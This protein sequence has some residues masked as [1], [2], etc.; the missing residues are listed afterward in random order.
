MGYHLA[1]KGDSLKGLYA[2]CDNT[3]CP[4]RSHFSLAFD[5]LCGG[6]PILQLRMKGVSLKKR[7]EVAQR[8]MRLKRQFFF[9]FIINDDPELV[10]DVGA[11]GAHVG[12]GDLSVD[13][14]RRFLGPSKLI[15]YSAHSLEEAREAEAAGADY[16][17][18]GAIFPSPLKGPGHPVQG[19]KR[20]R[21]V[22]S[23]LSIPVV[24]I[25]GI[26]H[27]NVQSVLETGVASVAMISALAGASN[28][29][30]ATRQMMELIHG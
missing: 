16:V 15:G 6:A 27:N 11:D 23:S 17:A 13:A 7:R 3:P 10:R 28:V 26:D 21:R 2:L 14:C 30:C 4:G 19:V 29:I 20:L 9:C 8:I 25:G 1:I 5:L 18:F 22:V 24:A 12:L